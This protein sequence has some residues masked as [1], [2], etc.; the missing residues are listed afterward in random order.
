MLF[1]GVPPEIR[2]YFHQTGKKGKYQRDV[3]VLD[4]G[5][6]MSPHVLKTATAFGGSMVYENRTGIGRYGVGGPACRTWASPAG[7]RVAR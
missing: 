2:V 5:K 4:N 1:S 7:V 3:L 6:G